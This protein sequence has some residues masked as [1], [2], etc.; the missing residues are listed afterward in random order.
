MTAPAGQKAHVEPLRD[1]AAPAGSHDLSRRRFLTAAV[2]LG[3]AAVIGGIAGVAGAGLVGDHPSGTAGAASDFQRTVPFHGPHQ[4]GIVTPAQDRLAFAAF[5]LTTSDRTE[6][7]RLLRTWTDAAALMSAGQ[8]VGD[9]AGAPLAPPVDTGEAIGLLPASLTLTVGFGPGVFDGR[10]SLAGRRPAALVDLPP[11]AGDALDP[12][13]SGGDLCV[14]ACADDPQVAFHAVRNLA[15][16]ARGVADVRWFQFGFGRTS[17]TSSSQVTP[18]NLL[19]FKDGTNNVVAEDTAALDAYV[20][21]GPETDQA[22]LRGGS[23]LVCRR[24]RMRIESWD[25]TSLSEQQAVIGRD[26][27]VGAPLGAL[28]E[29]APV[30]LAAVGLDDQPTIAGDAHIRLAAPSTND[31]QRILRR[32]YSFTDGID[33]RTGELD[34]GLFFICYQ[35]DPRRQF[36][37][38]QAHLSA[39]DALNEYIRH[40]GSGIFACPPGVGPGDWWGSGLFA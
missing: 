20:W 27:V 3:G 36:V 13:R 25:R 12:D 5:D 8:P 22:W 6:V 33:T 15:R 37:P 30:D 40:T 39:S 9:V 35:Q 29:H 16:L 38:I 32:G 7:A 18:R 21:V 23:Y 14:Q 1:E 19:G 4:A 26:K 11:F 24:I 34:A 10:F 2:G 28:T 17:S 31:G